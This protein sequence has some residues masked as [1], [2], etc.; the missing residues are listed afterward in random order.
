MYG[1]N[2]VTGGERINEVKKLKSDF[3]I[4]FRQG[5]FSLRKWHSDKTILET[6]DGINPFSTNV[7][8]TD[9]PGSWFLLIFE[10]H[11][12]KSDILSKDAGH[13]FL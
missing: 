11:L 9:K 2:L 6:N 5:G 4:L 3:I 7:P 8:L 12:W 10:K 13:R 1:D